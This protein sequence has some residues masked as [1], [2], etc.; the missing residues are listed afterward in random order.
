MCH[1]LPGRVFYSIVTEEHKRPPRRFGAPCSLAYVLTCFVLT[2]RLACVL[3][4]R[5][6]LL[7]ILFDNAFGETVERDFDFEHA[8]R[9]DD[10]A[11]VDIN[12]HDDA[13]AMEAFDVDRVVGLERFDVGVA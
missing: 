4:A 3:T 11:L 8:G 5:A 13:F 2:C 9:D 10:D 1:G 6:C 12:P 7:G